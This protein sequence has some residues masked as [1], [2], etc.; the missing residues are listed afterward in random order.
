MGKHFP[1]KA[2]QIVALEQFP[3]GPK[4]LT[5]GYLGFPY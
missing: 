5:I 1:R 3:K 4:Y 2:K